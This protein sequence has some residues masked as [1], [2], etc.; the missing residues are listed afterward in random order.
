VVITPHVLV[1]ALVGRGRPPR[2][3]ALYGLATHLVL[4]AVPHTDY[5]LRGRRGAL[6][7]AVDA[8]AAAVLLAAT[9]PDAGAVAS[10]TAAL[11]PD[12]HAQLGPR[13]VPGQALHRAAH[14]RRPV[15][16]GAGWLVQAA[17]CVLAVSALARGDRP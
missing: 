2:R 10:A 16:R 13:F 6:A 7:L 9:R 15:R 14:H 4:D 5:S 12:V 11:A 1:G 8:S 3:A 17:V